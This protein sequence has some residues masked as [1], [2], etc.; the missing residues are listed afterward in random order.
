M[1]VVVRSRTTESVSAKRRF[2]L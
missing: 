2:V 1:P